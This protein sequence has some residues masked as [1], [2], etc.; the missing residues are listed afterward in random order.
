M[1]F[2]HLFDLIYVPTKNYQL[3]SNSMGV[4]ACTKF[5]N[6]GIYIHN[7]ESES[8]LE[9]DM[10]TGPYLCLYQILSKYFKPHTQEFGFEIH[11]RE[12]AEVILVASDTPTGPYLCLYKIFQAIKKSLS[13]QEFGSEIYSVECTRKRT[14]QE[15]SFLH[16]TLLLDLIYVPPKYYQII[17]D[18]MGVIACTTF[19][20]QGR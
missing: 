1:S 6:Q 18:S 4:M 13:A 19:Q 17:S 15:L 10:P 2:L 7:G 14:K 11:S 12:V 3:I 8:T 16:V 20:I 5:R 9:C